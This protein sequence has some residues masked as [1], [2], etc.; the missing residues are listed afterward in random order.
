MAADERQG[1]IGPDLLDAELR[2]LVHEEGFAALRKS[3]VTLLRIGFT[4]EQVERIYLTCAPG[5]VTARM[6]WY[7]ADELLTTVQQP[8]TLRTDAE[9]DAMARGLRLSLERKGVNLP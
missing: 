7:A 1:M 8:T 3:V 9:A 6:A 2:Q 5:T 4:A